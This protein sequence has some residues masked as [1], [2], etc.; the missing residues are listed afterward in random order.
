ME[1]PT[2]RIVLEDPFYATFYNENLY[3]VDDSFKEA[4]A[5]TITQL[6]E[7]NTQLEE[8]I[9]VVP[10]LQQPLLV[11]VYFQDSGSALASSKGFLSK[12]LAAVGHNTANTDTVVMNKLGNITAKE[13]I[14]QSPAKRVIGFGVDKSNLDKS[15]IRKYDGKDII[16]ARPLEQLPSNNAHKKELWLLLKQVFKM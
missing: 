14:D 3:L 16:I 11:L 6:G 15:G 4:Q 13:I 9:P 5:E 1:A 8:A 7:A 10:D 2:Q 12:I